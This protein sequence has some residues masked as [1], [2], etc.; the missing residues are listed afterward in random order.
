MRF[1]AFTL[2]RLLKH[3]KLIVA[4]NY[5]YKDDA[6]RPV[7]LDM[8]GRLLA[9]TKDS[10]GL[11]K[12]DFAGT[13]CM[14][15]KTDVFKELEEPWFGQEWLPAKKDYTSDDVFLCRKVR[16]AGYDIWI[17]QDLSKMVSHIGTKEFKHEGC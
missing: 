13:G 2:H 14:L 16:E 3:D 7:S 10:T 8:Q 17:D 12:V 6:Y 15:I 11:V 4:A 5:A 1:P 9:T